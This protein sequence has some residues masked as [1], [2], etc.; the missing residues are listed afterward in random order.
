MFVGAGGPS[1]VYGDV[2]NIPGITAA[3]ALAV[4]KHASGITPLSGDALE[5]ADVDDTDNSTTPEDVTAQDALLILKYSA[6]IISKFPV[7]E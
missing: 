2:D 1:C 4:L 3:D 5:A 6:G 7:E